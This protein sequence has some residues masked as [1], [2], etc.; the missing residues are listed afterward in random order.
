GMQ[1]NRYITQLIALGVGHLKKLEVTIND[2][3]YQAMDKAIPY[4]DKQIR[5]DYEDLKRYKADMSKDNLSYD[6]IQYLY[7]RSF[8][9]NTNEQKEYYD[10]F[11]NQAKKYWNNKSMYMK[12]MIAIALYRA[13]E[14]KIAKEIIESLRQTSVHNEEMGM[15]WKQDAGFYWFDAPIE[16]QALMIEAFDEVGK[17]EKSVEEMK[18]WL[19][20]NKQTND[21]KTTRATVEA[22]NALLMTGAEMLANSEM[23]QIIVGGKTI[24]P[25][26]RPDTKVEAGT[27]YFKTSWA[28]AEVNKDFGKIEVKNPNKSGTAWGGVYWQYFEQ[29][30]KIQYAATPLAIQKQLFIEKPSATGPVLTP[31]TD[32]N[33]IKQGDKIIVRVEIRVDRPME[34]VHLKDMRAAGFEPINVLSQ[35]KYQ[36]GLGYYESTK[37]LATHFF[38][39]YLPKG[40]FVFEYPLRATHKGDFSNGITTMQCMYAPEFTTH[41]KGIRVKID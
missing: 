22:C 31:I 1:D 4:L 23:A 32:N 17:D 24:N 15:Y 38:M 25:N 29:L 3:L 21:W 28:G 36:G 13:K 40:T 39:D 9:L 34:Y 7:M 18:I 12:G 10:Y 5:K 30:D 19:L 41:S 11:F 26:E 20:K 14:E 35:Y 8:Y 2:D 27:G 6:Q 37:D 16:R 33:T